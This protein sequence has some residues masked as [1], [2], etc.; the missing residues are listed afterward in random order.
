VLE[1]NVVDMVSRK[2]YRFKG[3]ATIL[4]EGTQFEELLDFYRRRG[5]TSA[6]RHIVL[7]K[8]ERAAPLISLAYDLGQSET[9]VR[10]RWLGYW[11][12]LWR[13]Q[14]RASYLPPEKK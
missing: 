14:A 1:I 8:V 2:G 3:S 11:D 7:V 9:Q 5:S 6:K 13:R 12:N 10:A 4:S